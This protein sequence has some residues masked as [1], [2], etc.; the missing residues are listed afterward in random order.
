M[1]KITYIATLLSVLII[2]YGCND[3]LDELP[4]NRTLVDSKEKITKLLVSAYPS[5]N[6]NLIPELMSDNTADMGPLNPNFTPFYEQVANWEDIKERD[7][8]GIEYIWEGCYQ[9]ISN[10]NL[11]LKS[12]EELGGEGLSEQKGEALITR[13]YSH[14]ILVNIFAKH[15]NKQ[16]SDRDLGIVYMEEP[17]TKLSPKYKRGTVKSN[18]EKIERDLEEGLKLI[19]NDYEVSQYHFTKSAAKA[20]AARFYLYYEKWDKAEKYATECLGANPSLRNYDKLGGLPQKV[21]VVTAAY[22]NDKE[23][24]LLDEVYTSAA[25]LVF[26]PYDPSAR[27]NH[28]AFINDGQTMFAPTPW[29]PS[30][31]LSVQNYRYKPFIYDGNNFDKKLF[32]KIPFLFEY[33]DPVAKSGYYKTV[34]VVFYTDETLLVRAEAK[35]LQKK[36]EEALEDLN[37]FTDNLYKYATSDPTTSIE[38][39]NKFYESLPYSSSTDVNAINQK[40]ELHPKF[41]IEKGTQENMLHYVLQCRRI[42]TLH[43]GLRWFDLKRY[44]IEVQRVVYDYSGNPAEVKVLPVDDLRRAIQLPSD[45]INS[46]LEANPR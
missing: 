27:Y 26:G 25:G 3:F 36:Y 22:I 24:N 20:F 19:G 23:A 35:I 39:I 1:K 13:A 42:L 45:V 7:N 21:K 31:N 12:I 16:T 30:S 2:P 44:G 6:H 38:E 10:A 34:S 41:S 8:D 40:K 15:Y 4:D 29:N 37:L 43:E 14:F 9:A 32:I 28:T 33:T 18:Y 46:G 5:T 17:E 11:A